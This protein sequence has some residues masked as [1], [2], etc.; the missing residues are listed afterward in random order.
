M[1]PVK[2]TTL[3]ILWGLLLLLSC[4][5]NN[6]VTNDDPDPYQ[7]ENAVQLTF[8]VVDSNPRWSPQGNHIVFERYNYIYLLDISINSVFII[9]EWNKKMI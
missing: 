4:H 1:K 3:V 9:A 2:K 7:F 8:N 5:N 6:P